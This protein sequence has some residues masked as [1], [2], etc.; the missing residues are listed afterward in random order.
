L[1]KDYTFT[2]QHIEVYFKPVELPI[3]ASVT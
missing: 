2:R 3:I 1:S